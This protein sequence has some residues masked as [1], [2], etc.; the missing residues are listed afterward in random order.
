MAKPYSDDLRERAVAGI[1]SGHSCEEVAELYNLSPQFPRPLVLVI[2]R[3][4]KSRKG[5]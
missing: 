1:Q 5:L 4:R 3:S 2:R